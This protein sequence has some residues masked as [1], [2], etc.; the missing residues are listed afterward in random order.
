LGL[1]GKSILTIFRHE[2]IPAKAPFFSLA[3]NAIF[4]ILH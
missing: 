3:G 4:S 1:E 2:E